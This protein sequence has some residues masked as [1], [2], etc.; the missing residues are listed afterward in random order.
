MKFANVRPIPLL[1]SVFVAA[2][3]NSYYGVESTEQNDEKDRIVGGQ[4][5]EQGAYPY[6]V[7]MNG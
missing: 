2:A 5:A 7:Q 1:V 3:T 6:Y 4:Q